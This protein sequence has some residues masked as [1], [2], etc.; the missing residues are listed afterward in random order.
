VV[1]FFRRR[2]CGRPLHFAFFKIG[3]FR[4]ATGAV[5]ALPAGSLRRR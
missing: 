3:G 5:F 2:F 4:N 1:R